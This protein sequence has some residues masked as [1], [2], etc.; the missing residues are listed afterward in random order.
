MEKISSFKVDHRDL[1]PGLYVSRTDVVGGETITTYDLRMIHV[2]HDEPIDPK[3][4]HTIEHLGA[5]LFRAKMKD[6]VIYFGPMGCCT[7]FYLILKGNHNINDLTR[8]IA[9]VMLTIG[10]W[11]DE[12]GI[13]GAT[14]KECG[15]Y[16]F[17]DLPGAREVARKYATSLV[18]D[19]HCE[20]PLNED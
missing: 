6:E 1:K 15:N 7:G 20:Y 19:F 14:E 16:T 9:A 18:N 2:N 3:V 11:T 10:N 5:T 8:G 4:M 12:L 13:P 17:H